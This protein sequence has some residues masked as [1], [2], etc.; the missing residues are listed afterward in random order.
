MDR[1]T[2]KLL[3]SRAPKVSPRDHGFLKG[4]KDRAELFPNLSPSQRQEF[5]Q[6]LQEIDYP[7]LTLETF[8]KDR[9]YLEVGQSVMKQL[10]PADPHQQL[11]VD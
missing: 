4:K 5:W 1:A 3:Q 6:Q 11:T 10:Y 7:I 9:S 2:V 8:F